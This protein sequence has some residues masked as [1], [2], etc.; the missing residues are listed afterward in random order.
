MKL[1]FLIYALFFFTSIYGQE[2]LLQKKQDSIY[3]NELLSKITRVSNIDS[4]KKELFEALKIAKKHQFVYQQGQLHKMLG[5]L[6]A[7]DYKKL[8]TSNYHFNKSLVFLRQAGDSLASFDHANN[9]SVNYVHVRDMPKAL[10]YAIKALEFSKKL[11]LNDNQKKD[12]KGAAHLLLG[13]IYAEMKLKDSAIFNLK[14]ARLYFKDITSP[15]QFVASSNLGELFLELHNYEESQIYLEE[16]LTGYQEHD[17]ID[18]IVY[19]LNR[20]GDLHLAMGSYNISLEYY[21]GALSKSV[22]ANLN[23]DRLIAYH[24]LIKIFLKQKNNDSTDVYFNKAFALLDTLEVPKSKVEMLKLKAAYLQDLGKSEEALLYLKLSMQLEDSIIKKENLPKV[25]TILIEQ[26]KNDGLEKL[27]GIKK[28]SSQKNY[29]IFGAISLLIVLGI[30]SYFLIKRYRNQL[31][32]SDE[33]KYRL[34]SS[35]QSE[36]ENSAYINR[37]LVATTANLALKT[38][39]LSK[40]NQLL[41]QIKNQPTQNLNKEILETQNQIKF[42]NHLDNLWREFFTHFEEVHPD[43]LNSIQSKYGIT[44]NDLKICA[45]IKMNLSNKDICQLMNV[46]PNTIRVNI[47]RIKKKLDIPTGVSVTEFLAISE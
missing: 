6:Y 26:E 8:D 39:L 27:E 28:L 37:K 3:I 18:G 12:Y 33:T 40:V 14:K 23:H 42:Q 45:F 25:T 20:F 19:G 13:S 35:L 1:P 4:S 44:Q 2:N 41:N 7:S 9:I 16:A 15:Q 38:D 17:V 46:N 31:N 43:F 21:K 36:K 22:V 24:G 32:V 10:E 5:V 11:N 47:H 29:W 34:E 30:L